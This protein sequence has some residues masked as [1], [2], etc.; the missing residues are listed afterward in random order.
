MA[1][2][3]GI[4]L[5]QP[6]FQLHF[7]LEFIILPKDHVIYLAPVIRLVAANSR[8]TVR[9]RSMINWGLYTEGK[10]SAATERLGLSSG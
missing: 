10:W 9:V 1:I 6:K 2:C 8:I 7:K 4:K 3:L 5:L